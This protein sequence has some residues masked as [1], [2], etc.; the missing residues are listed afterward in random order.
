MAN[1]AGSVLPEPVCAVINTLSLSTIAL[2]AHF[3][4]ELNCIG[5]NVL[6]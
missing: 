6:K 1:S 2:I 5:A 4:N 3:W